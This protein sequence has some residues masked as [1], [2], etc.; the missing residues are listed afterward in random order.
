MVGLGAVV[1]LLMSGAVHDARAELRGEAAR[2]FERVERAI[3]AGHTHA[4]L[5][6]YLDLW[7]DDAQLVSARGPGSG[8]FDRVM[9]AAQNAATARQRFRRRPSP[10][11]SVLFGDPTV[12]LDGS[13]AI[14]RV[15][16]T[17]RWGPDTVLVAREEYRLRRRD[18]R[19]RVHHNRYWPLHKR[20]DGEETRYDEMTWAALDSRVAMVRA[21]GDPRGLTLALYNADRWAEAYRIIRGVT[22]RPGAEALD[23]SMR[24]SLAMSLGDVPDALESMR[25]ARAL[26]LEI[27][28]PYWAPRE[29]R[30]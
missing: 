4:D 17:V 26:D 19:W 7:T 18:G 14:L 5:A 3:V 8:P 20:I 2:V 12:E 9:T 10:Q 24:G 27:T 13:E 22:E 21:A 30:P 29:K 16:T 11:P 28:L 1:A 23:W 15:D 6:A 25:R